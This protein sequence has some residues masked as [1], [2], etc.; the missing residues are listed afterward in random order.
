MVV[1]GRYKVKFR[2]DLA[3]NDQTTIATM[4]KHGRFQRK[5]D[6]LGRGH[7][8]HRTYPPSS[9]KITKHLSGNGGKHHVSRT[10]TKLHGLDKFSILDLAFL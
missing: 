1:I 9:D 5:L 4:T 7:F 8:G 2:V 6:P 3:K 10:T